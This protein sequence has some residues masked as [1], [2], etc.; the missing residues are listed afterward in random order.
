M[1]RV[2]SRPHCGAHPP[3]DGGGPAGHGGWGA[4]PRRLP[5][6]L[7]FAAQCKPVRKGVCQG[8]A[9]PRRSRMGG[10]GRGLFCRAGGGCG[11]VVAAG[12][13]QPDA[14]HPAVV[15]IDEPH[16]WV[17]PGRSGGHPHPGAQRAALHR[18]WC[19]RRRRATGGQRRFCGTS[20]S[21]VLWPPPF[22]QIG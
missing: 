5:R 16:L 21:T 10:Y 12:D 18:P 3:H 7:H 2:E 8:A 11:G 19:G 1:V 20:R 15:R 6:L 4:A 22:L 13:R 17:Y 14:G 9:A